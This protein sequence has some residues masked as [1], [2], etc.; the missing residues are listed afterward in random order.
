MEQ[1]LYYTLRFNL[2]DRAEKLGNLFSSINFFAELYDRLDHLLIEALPLTLE[3]SRSLKDFGDNSFLFV[4]RNHIIYPGQFPLD[5]QP[6]FE[7]VALWMT[8]SRKLFSTMFHKESHYRADKLKR[9]LEEL[10]IKLKFSDLISYRP[11]NIE[12]LE[13]IILDF[14]NARNFLDSEDGLIAFE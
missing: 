6:A 4:F 12:E 7:D 14:Q 8:E 3:F 10:A 1:D 13:N 11:L 5:H 9:K 2:N